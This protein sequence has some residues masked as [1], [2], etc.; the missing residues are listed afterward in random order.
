MIK[1]LRPKLIIAGSRRAFPKGLQDAVKAKVFFYDPR[2]LEE[3]LEKIRNLGEILGRRKEAMALTSRLE[4]RLSLVRPLPCRPRVVYEISQRP[5]KV[6][7]QKSIVSAI[8]Q[9]AGG[10]NVITVKRKH[11]LISPEEILSLAP[12]IYVYQVGPMNKNPVPP[13]KRAYFSA[14]RSKVI[15]VN[16]FEFA[17]PGINAFSAVVQLNRILEEFCRR[18]P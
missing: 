6:A 11:V 16:E 7:G 15:R 13:G 18:I 5:L 17:R 8:I 2:S 1:A 9:A 14:L 10:E 12:D 4:A 3:I